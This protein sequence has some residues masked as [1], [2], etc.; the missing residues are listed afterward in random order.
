MA[1]PTANSTPPAELHGARRERFRAQAEVAARRAGRLSSARLLVF[2]AAAGALLGAW[3]TRGA[4]R[5]ALLLLGLALAGA[6]VA[7]VSAHARAR[8]EHQW[9]SE[10][11]RGSEL[12]LARMRRDWNALP[13]PQPREAPPDHAYAADVDVFGHASLAQLLGAVSTAPGRQRLHGWLLAASPVDDVCERQLAVAELAPELD[14]RDEF[15]ARGRLAGRVA[16]ARIRTFVEWA[17]G[18]GWLSGRRGIRTAAWLVPAVTLVLAGLQM[19]GVLREGWWGLGLAAAALVTWRS[20]RQAHAIFER[21][22]T[23]EEGVAGYAEQLRLLE[24]HRFQAPCLER[25]AAELRAGQGAARALRRLDGLLSYAEGRNNTLFWLPA[26]LIFLWDLQV[27]RA[28]ERWQATYGPHVA[29]WFKALGQADALAALAGLAHDH[30]DWS[31]PELDRAGPPALRAQALGHP[32]LP[33]VAAVPNDVVV[34][35]PGSYLLV[36]GSNMSGKST[37]LRAIG[38]NAVLAQAGGP[39]CAARLALPP[40]ELWTSMRVTDSLERGVS[41]F[42]AELERLKAIVDAARRAESTGGRT[43]LYLVDEVLQGTNSA[44]RQVAARRIIRHLVDHG[45]I[46]AVTTH[47]L[48]LADAPELAAAT[49]AVHFRETVHTTGDAPPL[50]F[51]YRLRPG[52]ATSRNA[53]KLMEIVGLG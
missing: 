44:E 19:A 41:H 48:E 5:L 23:G 37:L 33:P 1:A 50:S 24:K 53:L 8:R 10:L 21:A 38:L 26:Q 16:P 2:V 17:D 14:L 3:D 27:L 12:A 25:L 39:V 46:G 42:M 9:R 7:L 15:A 6:F 45:A 31:F 20:S 32:L 36:T 52:L 43:L 4:P 30:P 49:I 18:P 47:D 34:G 11:A 13:P 29:G 40:V 28:L 35:P 22:A 51:D